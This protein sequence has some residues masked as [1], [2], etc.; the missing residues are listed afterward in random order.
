MDKH[1][2]VAVLSLVIIV[3]F[4]MATAYHGLQGIK[5]GSTY[6]Q[7]TFLFDPSARFSDFVDVV[8]DAHTLNPYLEYSSA[9]YPLLALTGYVFWLVPGY[10][11]AVFMVT[12]STCIIML[13][14]MT[15]RMATRSFTAV[16]TLLIALLSYPFLIAVDRANFELLVYVF[17][18]A[19]I[20]LFSRGQY[21]WSASCLGIAIALKAYPVVLLAL[22]LPARQ[23]RVALIGVGVAAIATVG[24]LLCFQGGLGPNVAFIL[25][26]GNVQSNPLFA[27]FTSFSS[28]VVQRGVSLLTFIK[29]I[30]IETGF[31]RWLPDS[32]FMPVYMVSA[33]IA[34]AA[35]LAYAVLIERLLWRRVAVLVLV[36]LLLPP[37]SA[38][39]KLLLIYLLLYLF[40]N[41]ERRSRLDPAILAVF[42][43]LLVPKSYYYLPT[44][45]SD[46]PNVHDTSIAV[47]SNVILLLLLGLL[48]VITGLLERLRQVRKSRSPVEVESPGYRSRAA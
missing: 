11:L 16:H 42:G 2:K 33:A 24:S 3:G 21:G 46:V 20:Y 44:V 15:L 13:S 27:Q 12:M 28:E 34:G 17:L 45:I 48:I 41:S 14:Y 39:Y 5:P 37:I 35:A 26:G 25:Q 22:Y 40:L 19:F 47:P 6:P 10:P 1:A 31:L 23:I 38:D 4:S 32:V 36:M 9:Q 29:V 18:L 43:M 8:R 7:T 30:S